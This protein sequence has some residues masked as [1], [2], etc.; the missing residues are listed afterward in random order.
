MMPRGRAR[1]GVEVPVR[2]GVTSSGCPA[3]QSGPLESGAE[4]EI[5]P[6]GP[7]R[8]RGGVGLF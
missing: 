1:F 3:Q 2:V 7:A 5:A 6:H 8:G 4:S